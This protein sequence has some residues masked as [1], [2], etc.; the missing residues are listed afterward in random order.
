M[1]APHGRVVQLHGPLKKRQQRTRVLQLP[2]VMQP[3]V[4]QNPGGGKPFVGGAM[5]AGFS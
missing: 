2:S 5:S 4:L 3:D 1:G